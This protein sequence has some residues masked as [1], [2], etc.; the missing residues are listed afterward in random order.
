MNTYYPPLKVCNTQYPE[1]ININL[2]NRQLTKSK[3]LVHQNLF[4]IQEYNIGFNY[5]TLTN[6]KTLEIDKKLYQ[7]VKNNIQLDS[8]IHNI[9]TINNKCGYNPN[10][11]PYPYNY[12]VNN[13]VN[14]CLYPK[15]PFNPCIEQPS[16]K[17]QFNKPN[18]WNIYQ[19]S[20]AQ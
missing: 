16:N 6:T 7:P 13:S 10:L 4:R 12:P 19:N 17:K 5:K 9:N 11:S 3:G 2:L 20:V 15:Y 18:P 14:V 1:Q 8:E